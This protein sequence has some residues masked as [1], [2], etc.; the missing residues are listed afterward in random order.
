[1]EIKEIL[2]Y[3]LGA[4]GVWKIF[5]L[6]L[7]PGRR[8]K[9]DLDNDKV[10][11]EEITKLFTLIGENRAEITE[12]YVQIRDAN[13]RITELEGIV[14]DKEQA[15]KKLKAENAKLAEEITALKKRT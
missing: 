2:V 15:I 3:L 4:G 1:M 8:R 10:A 14:Y 12:A 6:A 5:E 11:R 13:R 9:Q 7:L